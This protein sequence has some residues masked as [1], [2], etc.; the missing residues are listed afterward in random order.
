MRDRT[1]KIHFI[2]S[3]GTIQAELRD[4]QVIRNCPEIISTFQDS[5]LIVISSGKMILTSE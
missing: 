2:V 5:S 3:N 1:H 4:C